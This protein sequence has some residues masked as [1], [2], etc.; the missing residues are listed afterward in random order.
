M[1][2]FFESHIN[3]W[4]ETTYDTKKPP[5]ERLGSAI[6]V[7]E[8]RNPHRE[9]EA[10]EA[11]SSELEFLHWGTKAESFSTTDSPPRY[12]P[13]GSS[14]EPTRALHPTIPQFPASILSLDGSRGPPQPAVTEHREV[15]RETER[16]R[17][18]RQNSRELPRSPVD[19]IRGLR[20]I[21]WRRHRAGPAP[22][23]TWT[24]PQETTRPGT[25]R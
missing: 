7:R 13:P 20:P 22:G 18:A 16:T 8:N 24:I 12:D 17:A 14:P 23:R 11:A 5:A 21:A 6:R 2:A 19:T 9:S 10:P 4:Q 1:T 15:P 3:D 25:L